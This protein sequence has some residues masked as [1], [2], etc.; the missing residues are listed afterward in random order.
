MIVRKRKVA[1]ISIRLLSIFPFF[2]FLYFLHSC[3]AT[4]NDAKYF[5]FIGIISPLSRTSFNS[6]LSL[7]FYELIW[8]E[9]KNFNKFSLDAEIQISSSF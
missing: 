6:S 9:T 2:Y 8:N 5:G 1:T 4:S 7:F 3:Q